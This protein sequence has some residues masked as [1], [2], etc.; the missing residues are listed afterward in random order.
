VNPDGFPFKESLRTDLEYFTRAGIVQTP[1]DLDTAVDLSF[2]DHA[3]QQ[4]G[5]FQR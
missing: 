5:R 3:L 2:T 1:P 4:L